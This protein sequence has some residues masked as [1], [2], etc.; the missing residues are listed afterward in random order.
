MSWQRTNPNRTEPNQTEPNQT[1]ANQTEPNRTPR[2]CGCRPG[3]ARKAFGS[4]KFSVLRSFLP[5]GD[6]NRQHQ[7]SLDDTS[8]VETVACR[9]C[10]VSPR[11]HHA[12]SLYAC[13]HEKKP[14]AF[15][16]VVALSRRLSRG[17]TS[18][19]YALRVEGIRITY[20]IY[21]SMFLHMSISEESQPNARDRRFRWRQSRRSLARRNLE[22]NM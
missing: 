7:G 9:D 18:R 22:L 13:L 10:A 6:V 15:S 17:Y 8:A 16:H 21:E 4:S 1:K 20:I 12:L 11:L 3:W 19:E 2:V 14:V 5:C